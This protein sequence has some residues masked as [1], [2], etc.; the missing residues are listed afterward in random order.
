VIQLGGILTIWSPQAKM[1]RSIFVPHMAI[2]APGMLIVRSVRIKR[3]KLSTSHIRIRGI[4][5]PGKN[6]YAIARK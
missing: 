3:A 2:I 4:K 5:N 6:F 1:S